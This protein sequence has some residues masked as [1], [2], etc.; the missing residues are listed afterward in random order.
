MATR[1]YPGEDVAPD[2]AVIQALFKVELFAVHG[3]VRLA[4]RV[5]A[6]NVNP[7]ALLNANL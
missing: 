7:Y 1:F 6:W 4:A 2:F 5:L 3:P